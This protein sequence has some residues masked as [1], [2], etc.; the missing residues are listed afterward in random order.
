MPELPLWW[1]AEYQNTSV[2]PC[3]QV[4]RVRPRQE[5]PRRHVDQRRRPGRREGIPSPPSLL[6]RQG[7]L[8]A[9]QGIV[10]PRPSI[11]TRDFPSFPSNIRRECPPSLLIFQG[12]FLR[13]ES[14]WAR[15]ELQTTCHAHRGCAWKDKEAARGPAALDCFFVPRRQSSPRQGREQGA[16]RAP[17]AP[18]APRPALPVD[19]ECR[20]PIAS[21]TIRLSDTRLAH[22]EW[23]WCRHG[24][25][26]D[27][28]LTP[29]ID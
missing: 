17:R 11:I 22:S 20:Q 28:R 6:T 1:R 29:A 15:G 9:L 16:P 3:C 18:T 2:A 21:A 19:R 10:P 14:A 7:C 13:R 5:R 4:L 23:C 26:S 25:C 24:A 27:T 8:P 12:I